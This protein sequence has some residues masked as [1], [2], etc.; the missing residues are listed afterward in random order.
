MP[1]RCLGLMLVVMATACGLPNDV[2]SVDPPMNT[3]ASSDAGVVTPEPPFRFACDHGQALQDG[4]NRNMTLNG[5]LGTR[6][7]TVEF[8]RVDR[9]T[10]MPII[11]GWHGMGD[12]VGNFKR[13]L[14]LG[15]GSDEFPF[16]LVLPE[17]TNMNFL[18]PDRPGVDWDNLDSVTG[19]NN[20]EVALVESVIGCLMNYDDIAWDQIYSFGFSAGA[21]ATNM[22]HSRLP[23]VFAATAALSG[24]W[25]NDPD[26][27]DL[28][29]PSGRGAN[30]GIEPDPV[31]DPLFPE[32]RGVVLL[33][34]GGSQD[35]YGVMG[36]EVINFESAHTATI[37]HMAEN[38]RLLV[39]CAH[40]TGHRPHP[41]LSKQHYF[42]F[43]SAHRLGQPS[44]YLTDGLPSELSGPCVLRLP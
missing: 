4:L 31:W 10:K 21:L 1:I 15:A 16:I 12:N 35:N 22:L 17:S 39:D 36:I 18:D 8:P 9:G 11:F 14:N 43:L 38:N 2:E 24:A 23:H 3:S 44:P 40:T 30:L 7:V 20:K 19:D 41:Q 28:L 25:F 42:N 26:Q 6:N 27:I 5:G 33:T 13:A 29:D 37:D 34:H 32:D